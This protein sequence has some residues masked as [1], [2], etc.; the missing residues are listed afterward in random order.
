MEDLLSYVVQ[1][2]GIEKIL[3]IISAMICI[4]LGYKL[5]RHGVNDI[6]S[7]EWKSSNFTFKLTRVS[8]G[9]FF[10]VLGTSVLLWAIYNNTEINLQNNYNNQDDYTSPKK[11]KKLLSNANIQVLMNGGS[12]PSQLY[13][14]YN[15]IIDLLG[16]YDW[17]GLT[18]NE[19]RAVLDSL[20]FIKQYRD[21]IVKNKFGEE[22]YNNFIK[23]QDDY[24][25]G[26]KVPQ[27]YLPIIK[28]INE[29]LSE[30]LMK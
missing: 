8:P 25:S 17:K 20:F 18:T 10:A 4:I 28:E 14:S 2:R 24:F 1:Y 13:K 9:T 19:R 3:I 7:A 5:F 15:T 30:N 12:S 21:Y 16:E 26:K 6:Q 22:N 27:E 23:Y 11:P 29:S